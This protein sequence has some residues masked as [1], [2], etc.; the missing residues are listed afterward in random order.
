MG[1]LFFRY[2]FFLRLVLK[3]FSLVFLNNC[4]SNSQEKISKSNATPSEYNK[5]FIAITDSANK[6]MPDYMAN[7]K[8]LMQKGFGKEQIEIAKSEIRIYWSTPFYSGCLISDGN[9][10]KF[11]NTF[12]ETQKDSVF[13]YL[14]DSIVLY[15]VNKRFEK[16]HDLYNENIIMSSVSSYDHDLPTNT[17]DGDNMFFIE[18]AGTRTKKSLLFRTPYQL[19]KKDTMAQKIC[20]FLDCVK[21]AY[22]FEYFSDWTERKK[23]FL[24]K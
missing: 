3:V 17:A 11:Y 10:V 20:E 1:I 15:G 13:L 6:N 12:V 16:C 5:V 14:R 24:K 22:N 4:N 2:K 21:S 9:T 8:V 23:G 18:F 19:A 7:F